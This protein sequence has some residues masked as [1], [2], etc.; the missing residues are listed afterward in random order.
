VKTL[1]EN[2]LEQDFKDKFKPASEEELEKRWGCSR[3]E[4]DDRVVDML[5]TAWNSVADD[6][7]QNMNIGLAKKHEMDEID[8]HDVR[9]IVFDVDAMSAVK[10]EDEMA[11]GYWRS[12]DILEKED[13]LK[14]AFPD[15]QTYG[16]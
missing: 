12:L 14:R 2:L 16:Y 6:V 10:H 5:E 3:E 4:M 8:A 13:L 9:S 1:L 7:L 15:S 11:Y